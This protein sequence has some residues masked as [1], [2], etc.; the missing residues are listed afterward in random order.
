MKCP[1]FIYDIF[2]KKH[3][4]ACY[5]ETFKEIIEIIT[6]AVHNSNI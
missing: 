3:T 1:F 5:Q 2:A 4:Q 6:V